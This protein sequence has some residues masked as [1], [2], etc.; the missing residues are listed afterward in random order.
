VQPLHHQ[1]QSQQGYGGQ[2]QH[3]GNSGRLNIPRK[4]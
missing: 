2:L 4:L 1:Q 3:L